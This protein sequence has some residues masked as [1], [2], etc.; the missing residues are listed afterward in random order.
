MP[1][2]QPQNDPSL[3]LA[4]PQQTEIALGLVGLVPLAKNARG[5]RGYGVQQGPGPWLTMCGPWLTMCAVL[6][7][8]L[9]DYVYAV[10]PWLLPF[11]G[12]LE[13]RPCSAFP[14]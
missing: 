8:A 4:L 5:E 10:L 3:K 11:L 12:F 7:R 2:G 9:A 1:L 13:V 6:P 14:T